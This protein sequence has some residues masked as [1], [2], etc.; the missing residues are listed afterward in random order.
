MSTV[1]APPLAEVDQ[2]AQEI[3]FP[4]VG[5]ALG[6]SHI[7]VLNLIKHLD[8][9]RFRASVLIDIGDG[10][11]AELFHDEGLQF[12]VMTPWTMADHPK[13]GPTAGRSE[14]LRHAYGH[15][16][17]LVPYLRTNRTP[18][19]HSNDGRIHVLGSVASKLTGTGHLWHHRSDPD[20]FSLRR[21]SP[22]GADH[23]VTVSRFAGPKPGWWSAAD[24]WTIVPSPFPTDA[25]PPDRA[26][27]RRQMIDTL[28]CSDDSLVVGFFANFARRKRP[29]DFVRAVAA[30]RRAYPTTPIMA[31][32]FGR[33]TDISAEEVK[34]LAQSLGVSDCV[35]LMGF[36]YPADEWLAG[37]D[38]LFVPAVREPFGRTLIEA[39]IVGTV[40][41]A[42]E[43]GGNPEAIEDDN[44][45]YL[46]PSKDA[47]AA[48]TVFH[49]I[50]RD[51]EAAAA[52]AA[53]AQTHARQRFG[54]QRHADAIMRI[55]QQ[56]LQ[57]HATAQQNPQLVR[58]SISGGEMPPNSQQHLP[59]DLP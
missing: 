22:I 21:I 47:V 41:V 18:I 25:P 6:G 37:C 48:A 1:G 53:R 40:V 5:N 49:K 54:M 9:E 58:P 2:N 29:L 27:C 3:A 4:L 36:R 50:E 56:L 11:V 33:A 51:R 30:F 44:T 16:K 59:R 20:A 39:M 35:H 15:L 52:L 14:L 57:R 45:G 28:V 17:A 7:S 32:L 42:V 26:I 34:N 8:R 12:K 43:D 19:L 55:Y 38:V 10:P 46:V 31:P 23:L 24:K 13:T